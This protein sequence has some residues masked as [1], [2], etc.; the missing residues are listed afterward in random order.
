MA[1]AACRLVCPM[2][3]SFGCDTI[4]ATL[5]LPLRERGQPYVSHRR[6]SPVFSGPP[7]GWLSALFG[8]LLTC[9]PTPSRPARPFLCR[10]DVL[11]SQCA[12]QLGVEAVAGIVGRYPSTC[13]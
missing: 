3:I 12:R 2:A 1:L 5:C 11:R 13:L 7:S 9:R 4:G 10:S 6:P 8:F